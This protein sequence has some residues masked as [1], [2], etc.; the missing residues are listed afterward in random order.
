MICDSSTARSDSCPVRLSV[1][2]H[3]PVQLTL[4][5]CA[6]RP[7]P[8]L[9]DRWYSRQVC[10]RKGSM[11]L[12]LHLWWTYE[13]KLLLRSGVQAEKLAAASPGPVFHGPGER[14]RA[15]VRQRATSLQRRPSWP[16]AARSC[17]SP[18]PRT[19]LCRTWP[20]LCG[21]CCQR[22]IHC[23]PCSCREI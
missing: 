10:T 13:K 2:L 23:I 1:T 19:R 7:S 4:R 16:T 15:F 3:R 12:A 20:A 5:V 6:A 8:R 21:R 22:G 14:D 11:D 9:S 17:C 18:S